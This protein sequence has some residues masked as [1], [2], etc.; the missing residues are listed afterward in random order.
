[1]FNPG[2]K[3]KLTQELC[4]QIGVRKL[5]GTVTEIVPFDPP[6]EIKWDDE[7]ATDLSLF[8]ECEITKR[9]QNETARPEILCRINEA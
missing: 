3:V 7:T 6:I 1:M 8:Y 9:R 5:H 2:D 4:R